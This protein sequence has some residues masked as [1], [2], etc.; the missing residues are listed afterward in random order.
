M[1]EE[2]QLAIVV[3][4]YKRIKIKI[5]MHTSTHSM[6]NTI[7]NRNIEEYNCLVLGINQNLLQE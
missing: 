5:H 4:K 1:H 3:K 2:Y 7:C 6:H